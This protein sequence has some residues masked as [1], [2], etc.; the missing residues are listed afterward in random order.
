MKVINETSLPTAKL[1]LFLK[2]ALKHKGAKLNTARFTYGTT[3]SV[4]GEASGLR[5]KSITI[6]IPR[7]FCAKGGCKTQLAQIIEHEIDHAFYGLDHHNMPDWWTLPVLWSE[8]LSLSE[9][10]PR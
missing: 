4:N 7:N 3:E 6:F 10:R 8:K 5:K 1:K 2:A 9:K